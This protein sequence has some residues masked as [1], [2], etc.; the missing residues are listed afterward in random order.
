MELKKKAQEE[1]EKTHSREDFMKIIK[2]NYLDQFLFLS[3]TLYKYVLKC[4]MKVMK[5]KG[6][7]WQKKECT[8]KK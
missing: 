3:K 6:I 8:Q 7:I 2:R 1:Y 4:I 5:G